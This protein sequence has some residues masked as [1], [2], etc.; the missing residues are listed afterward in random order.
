MSMPLDDEPSAIVLAYT[1]SIDGLTAPIPGIAHSF[2]QATDDDSLMTLIATGDRTAFGLF[3]RRH[4]GRC[5]AVAQQ[6]L[7]NPADAEE[8]TQDAFL[9][10]WQSASRWRPTE[11]RVTTWLFRVVVNLALD[12]T[13]RVSR[14]CLPI[15]YAAE[16]VASGSNPESQVADRELARILSRAI[17]KLPTRQRAALSLIVC[18]GLD[19][20]EAAKVMQVTVGTMESLLVR[21]RRRLRTVLAEATHDHIR[22]PVQRRPFM[23]DTS[24]PEPAVELPLGAL[25]SHGG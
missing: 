15:E 22:R 9:R 19:C 5:M 20:A 6:I 10:V 7:N 24:S 8:V 25:P 17:A 13:R 18:E 21:A 23:P 16:V 12:R 11:A 1:G 2:D 4:A 14:L 3:C